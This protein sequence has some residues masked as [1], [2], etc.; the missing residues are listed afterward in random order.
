MKNTENTKRASRFLK[1]ES[2]QI[3]IQKGMKAEEN[4]RERLA[5]KCKKDKSRIK[6][7]TSSA[8]RTKNSIGRVFIHEILQP[9]QK[10]N[11]RKL[12][13]NENR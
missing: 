8:G 7:A 2:Q 5:K 10:V 1:A 11:I 4:Y 9:M 3:I 12:E 13:T 6:S